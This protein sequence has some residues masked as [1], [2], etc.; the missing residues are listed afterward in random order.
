MT[1][2]LRHTE[3]CGDVLKEFFIL[4]FLLLNKY[5]QITRYARFDLKYSVIKELGKVIDVTKEKAVFHKIC[6]Q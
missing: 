5:P 3:S 4:K 1:Q 2:I 6:T